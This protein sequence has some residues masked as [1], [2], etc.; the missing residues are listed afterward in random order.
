MKI[1]PLGKDNYD[2][3]KIQAEAILVKNDV[4][5]YVDGSIVKPNDQDTMAAWIKISQIRFIFDEL[6]QVKNCEI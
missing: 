2:T 3:W 6:K 5:D 4:W 1:I